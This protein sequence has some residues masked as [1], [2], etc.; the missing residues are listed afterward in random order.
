M[1][2]GGWGG[3]GGVF[4]GISC[5]NQI[6]SRFVRLCHKFNF[7]PF[8]MKIPHSDEKKKLYALPIQGSVWYFLFWGLGGVDPK[9]F[10]SH[11]AARKFFLGLVAGPS[12]CSSEKV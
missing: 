3:G 4:A 8:Q 5:R 1:C 11:A 9:K 2:A 12:A 7:C 10:L 6:Y